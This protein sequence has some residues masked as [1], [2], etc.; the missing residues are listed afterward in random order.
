MTRQDYYYLMD[1]ETEGRQYHVRLTYQAEGSDPGDW[2]TPPCPA[3]VALVDVVV[4]QTRH[5][6]CQGNITRVESR[7]TAG[8]Y[9]DRVWDLLHDDANL[10]RRLEEA[11][12]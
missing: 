7:E 11:A 2:T 1:D 6:D 4:L 8:V 3:D 5:F 12:F 10:L 9:A